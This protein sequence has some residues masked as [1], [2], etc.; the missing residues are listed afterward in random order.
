M[1]EGE[2]PEVHLPFN[3]FD[4][5]SLHHSSVS[6]SH[7]FQSPNSLNNNNTKHSS[8][9]QVFLESLREFGEDFLVSWSN[10]PTTMSATDSTNTEGEDLVF[11]TVEGTDNQI[12]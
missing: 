12:L 7:L 9:I 6:G 3:P 11:K 1:S 4:T 10:S 5:E 2:E 8:E